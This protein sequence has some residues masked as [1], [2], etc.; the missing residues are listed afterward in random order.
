MLKKAFN[1][2]DDL[3]KRW[4]I[5][6]LLIQ[7]IVKKFGLEVVKEAYEFKILKSRKQEK[8]QNVNVPLMTDILKKAKT[9]FGEKSDFIYFYVFIY[10]LHLERRPSVVT[11]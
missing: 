11:G 8:N 6:W 3:N 4:F 7:L 10:F 1:I 2:L 5:N 9:A